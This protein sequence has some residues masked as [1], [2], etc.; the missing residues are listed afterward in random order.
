[1]IKYFIRTTLEREL[2]DS[3]T[4]ELGE[5]YTLLVDTEHKPIE[6]F[7]NQLS[8]ISEYDAVLLEDDVILCKNFKQRVEEVIG[9]YKDKIINFW[10]YPYEYFT[11]KMSVDIHCN[12][13]TY[14]PKGI[15]K[16]LSSKMLNHINDS[17]QYDTIESYALRE[18]K[19]KVVNYR[20]C[21]IQH[22]DNKSL[23]GNDNKFPYK[24]LRCTPYFVDY[25]EELGISYE[26]AWTKENR[27]RLIALMESKFKTKE[28][29]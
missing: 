15:G 22:K 26:D 1:M 3:V 25:L 9:K 6:S 12:V 17:K 11:T 24:I 14:Y 10:T 18:L 7:I 16:I 21:L 8:I 29:D 23:M 5:D 2:D 13:G 28:K 20:P 27:Q 19:L 4:R